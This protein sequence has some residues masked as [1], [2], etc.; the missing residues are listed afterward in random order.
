MS[1]E[2]KSPR[3]MFFKA[4]VAAATAC[5]VVSAGLGLG[6]VDFTATHSRVCRTCHADESSHWED[7][8]VHLPAH[9]R[10]AES[11]DMKAGEGRTGD[12]SADPAAVTSRCLSCHEDQKELEETEGHLVKLSHKVHVTQENLRCTDCHEN[13]T[14]DRYA[15]PTYRPTKQSCYVCHEHQQEIDGAVTKKNCMRCHWH[16]P[17]RPDEEADNDGEE[18]KKED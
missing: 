11:H 13:I 15:R 17:D 8:P 14:H 12:F 5:A 1:E 9:A 18:K 4:L 2:K 10:S 7:T 3:P 6:F 16:M